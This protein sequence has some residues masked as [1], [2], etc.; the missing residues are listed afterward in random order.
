M[1]GAFGDLTHQNL[2]VE[3]LL[4]SEIVIQHALVHSRAARDQID[5]R[6]S[7]SLT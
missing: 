1:I 7:E 5:P 2:A 6:A 4:G 3:V